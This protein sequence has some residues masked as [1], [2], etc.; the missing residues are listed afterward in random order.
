ME[1]GGWRMSSG[2]GSPLEELWGCFWGQSLGINSG[3]GIQ[4]NCI[5]KEM[6]QSHPAAIVVV[7]RVLVGSARLGGIDLLAKLL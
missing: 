7:R 3:E 6:T 5:Y 1:G 4:F 2:G